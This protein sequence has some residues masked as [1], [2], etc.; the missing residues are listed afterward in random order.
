[1]IM[2]CNE[3]DVLGVK[4]GEGRWGFN[5][6]FVFEAVAVRLDAGFGDR[7]RWGKADSI[8]RITWSTEI[9]GW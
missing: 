5:V 9:S 6:N 3:E 1:M 8:N 7:G 4:V 2:N